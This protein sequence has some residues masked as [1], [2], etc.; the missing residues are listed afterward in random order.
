MNPRLESNKEEEEEVEGE[1]RGCGI[2]VILSQPQ[3]ERANVR[4]EKRLEWRERDVGWGKRE[5]SPAPP[6]LATKLPS[7]EAL[8]VSRGGTSRESEPLAVDK[9]FPVDACRSTVILSS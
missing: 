1:N 5:D 6:V 2:R 7:T 4:V 8:Q 3:I 9:P